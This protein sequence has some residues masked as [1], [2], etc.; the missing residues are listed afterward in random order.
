MQFI[1]TPKVRGCVFCTLP[2]EEGKERENLVV[3]RSSH[4]FTLVNRYPYNSGHVLVIPSV[5]VQSFGALSSEALSNLHE[6][7]RDAIEAVGRA[8]HPDGYNVGMN[9][10]SVAGAG[11]AEH[12]HYHIVPRWGGDTSFMPI[13]ADTKVMNEHLDVTYQRLAEAFAKGAAHRP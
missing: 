4:A 11:I 7:L 8:Y 10:G 1:E 5:H 9:L 3:H 6:E 2:A 12:I 13:L